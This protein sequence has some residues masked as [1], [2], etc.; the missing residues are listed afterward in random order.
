MA[1]ANGKKKV[2][3]TGG[4]GL[5]GSVLIDRLGD[6]YELSSLDLKEA[7]GVPSHVAS[8]DDLDAMQPAFEGIDC[9]GS[10]GGGSSRVCGVGFC[11]AEQSCRDVQR[12]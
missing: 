2:L 1:D 11:A 9:G 12:V 10:F 4:A 3:I 8:L 7:D 5:I 6:R